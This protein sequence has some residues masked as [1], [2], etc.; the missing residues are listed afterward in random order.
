MACAW[1]WA[2]DQ[3]KF[4]PLPLC[5]VKFCRL[6]PAYLNILMTTLHTFGCSLTQGFALPDV[7]KPISQEE[8]TNLGRPFHWTDVH[9]YEPSKYAWPQVLADQLNIPVINHAR[10]GA[11]FQQIA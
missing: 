1:I 9:L 8:L 11:C 3:L 4:L 5:G 7:V 10:R 6:P 2:T